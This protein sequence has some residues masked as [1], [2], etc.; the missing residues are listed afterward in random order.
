MPSPAT[1]HSDAAK[2]QSSSAAAAIYYVGNLFSR[3]PSL[4]RWD[5]L[6]EPQLLGYEVLA[7]STPVDT[8]VGTCANNTTPVG[9]AWHLLRGAG[10]YESTPLLPLQFQVPRGGRC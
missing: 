2:A 5:R 8:I 1:G 3:N 9:K 6:I 7:A 4:I 10:V